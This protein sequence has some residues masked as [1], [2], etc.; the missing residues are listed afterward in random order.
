MTDVCKKGMADQNG[1][2]YKCRICA[3][4]PTHCFVLLSLLAKVVGTCD[5]M[6][7]YM[8][9]NRKLQFWQKCCEHLSPYIPRKNL[10]ILNSMEIQYNPGDNADIG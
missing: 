9:I 4:K 7:Q 3:S 1:T 5:A 10:C 8:D 2:K 6:V